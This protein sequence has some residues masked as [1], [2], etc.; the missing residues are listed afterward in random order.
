MTDHF[1]QMLT[2][3]TKEEILCKSLEGSG[4]SDKINFNCS[5][6]CSSCLENL[7]GSYQ[8]SDCDKT[9]YVKCLRHIED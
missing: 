9:L 5:N 3:N 8:C 6:V 4:L 7:T 2:V 1:A